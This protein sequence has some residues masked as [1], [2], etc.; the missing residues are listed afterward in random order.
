MGGTDVQRIFPTE[1]QL[2]H[3]S[4]WQ[5]SQVGRGGTLRKPPDGSNST[6]PAFLTSPR[7]KISDNKLNNSLQ[8]FKFLLFCSSDL[9]IF[10]SS[11]LLSPR[12]H[13][14]LTD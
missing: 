14:S 13:N 4:D 11:A 7:H 1:G 2:Y 3:Y 9:L 5:D 10:C 8:S 12:Q 6:Y